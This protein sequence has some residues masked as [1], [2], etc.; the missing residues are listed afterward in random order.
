ML[1]QIKFLLVAILTLAPIIILS[2]QVQ[3][4]FSGQA[5]FTATP[6]IINLS[7]PVPQQVQQQAVTATPTRTPTPQGPV[8]L[9]AIS[10]ANV[11]AAADIEAERLGTIRAGEIYPVIARYFRW[12]QFQYPTSPTGTGWVFDELVTIM[13]DISVV[14]DVSEQAQPTT[15]PLIIA[16]T[17]TQE[18]LLLLPGG[19]QTATAQARVIELP[20]V[21][22]GASAASIPGDP[23]VTGQVSST[24][25]PG[26]SIIL[27]PTFTYPP[28]IVAIAPTDVDPAIIQPTKPPE[29]LPISVENGVPSLVPI[30]IL[31]GLGLF[32]LLASASR[33]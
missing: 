7:S 8:V 10:E 4:E 30:L 21:S 6:A 2:Q 5:A 12:Y 17:Q 29:N 27:L 20:G 15:D 33:R 1:I 26:E 16:A 3:A 11:R 19:E 28:E 13:G 23:L 14:P 24:T 25:V 9:E 18:A 31:G 32:G 22:A